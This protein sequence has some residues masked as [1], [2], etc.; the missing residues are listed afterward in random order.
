[1]KRIRWKLQ[2]S[3]KMSTIIS[4]SRKFEREENNFDNWKKR[5]FDERKEGEGK[6]SK[7]RWKQPNEQT[8]QLKMKQKRQVHH[9]ED[10]NSSLTSIR[11][12]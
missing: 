12:S 8:K 5:K 10:A 2:K 1:M 3:F 9:Y 7:K 6:E 11:C 4:Y